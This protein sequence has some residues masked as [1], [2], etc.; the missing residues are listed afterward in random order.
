MTSSG[1]ITAVLRLAE[2]LCKK[3]LRTS[4]DNSVQ[5]GTV[6]QPRRPRRCTCGIVLIL[7]S[8]VKCMKIFMNVAFRSFLT[9]SNAVSVVALNLLSHSED[10][11]RVAVQ[12][13]VRIRKKKKK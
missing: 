13:R 6:T 12:V 3:T 8:Q 11:R 1:G 10:I 5:L 7:L 4:E 2:G 9:T